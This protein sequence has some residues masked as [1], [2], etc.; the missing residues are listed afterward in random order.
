MKTEEL[1]PAKIFLNYERGCCETSTMRTLHTF[2]ADFF[3]S[4]HKQPFGRLYALDEETLA[5]E[6]SIKQ[7]V[8][9][10]SYLVLLPVVGLVEY[11]DSQGSRVIV[12]AGQAYIA[13]LAAGANYSVF[14]PFQKDLVNYLQWRMEGVDLGPGEKGV[15]LS[16]DIDADKGAL[17]AQHVACNELFYNRLPFLFHIAK[18]AGRQEITYRARAS[19]SLLFAFVVQGAFELQNRLLHQGDGLALWET[20]TMEME[21]LSNDAIIVVLEMPPWL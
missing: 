11:A 8:A 9:K 5:P 17:A 7:V 19:N 21:A 4:D 20:A 16:F 13:F 14:N 12:E 10:D 6:T 18:L 2:N 15:L 1:L 3:Q